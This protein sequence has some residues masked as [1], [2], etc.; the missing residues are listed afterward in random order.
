MGLLAT[1]L[2]VSQQDRELRVAR[3]GSEEELLALVRSLLK[4]KREERALALLLRGVERFPESAPIATLT[5]SVEAS[6]SWR[7]IK[8]LL[9]GIDN[10]ISVE[11]RA[12]LC[13]LYRR[14][15]DTEHALNFGRQAIQMSP[16]DPC[17]YRAIGRIYLDQ[18]R[19]TEGTVEGMNALR[20][21]FKAHT[22][23]PQ[24]STTLLQLAE[25]FAILRAPIAA[26]RF[27]EPVKRAFADAMQ[28]QRLAQRIQSLAPERTTQ[29]QD[30][31]LIHERRT[32]G[33]EAQPEAVPV[34]LPEPLTAALKKTA[35]ETAGTLGCYVIDGNRRVVWGYNTSNWVDAEIGDCFGQLSEIAV[36]NS[37]KMGVGKFHHIFCRNAQINVVAGTLP[38]SLTWVYAGGP[39]T[40]IEDTEALLATARK[41]CKEMLP[42]SSL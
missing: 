15:G 21:L 1:L 9:A 40:R 10:D 13:D 30:L 17:G 41:L 29:I 31:F 5:Q 14:V 38:K 33:S 22:L 18:F 34:T 6:V 20:C 4:S 36:N 11:T 27:L 24:D 37:K 2:G 26:T 7:S 19:R 39:R 16:L 42:E 32:Y 35:E 8:A 23:S 28:V 3:S 25:I 12:R